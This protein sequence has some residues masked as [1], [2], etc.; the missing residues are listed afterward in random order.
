[1]VSCGTTNTVYHQS[2]GR[3]PSFDITKITDTE[4]VIEYYGSP[5]S[6]LAEAREEWDYRAKGVCQ[7]DYQY[8]NKQTTALC[9]G[10]NIACIDASDIL[11]ATGKKV[12]PKA[13]GIALCATS[14]EPK[15]IY[16]S[17][18]NDTAPS[19]PKEIV[20]VKELADGDYY[21]E[22]AGLPS[23]TIDEGRKTWHE[24]ASLTCNGAEYDY[25][26]AKNSMWQADL[27]ATGEGI[28]VKYKVKHAHPWRGNYGAMGAT[29]TMTGAIGCMIASL[30]FSESN[31]TIS[32]PTVTYSV[33]ENLDHK[34]EVRF[35]VVE[36][37][38]SCK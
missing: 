24:R 27:T 21:V 22:Y 25:K 15:V 14:S 9:S 35:P 28:D 31:T 4:F 33:D 37:K 32:E 16:S 26:L 23:N 8:K 7:G 2:G 17:I 18:A 5:L 11:S 29:C 10:E 19:E 36:G 3:T 30:I 1:M 38:V 20:I 12:Q 13:T 34:D 6:T